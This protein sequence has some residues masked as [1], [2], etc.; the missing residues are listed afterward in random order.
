MHGFFPSER[1]ICA[2]LY[3]TVFLLILA[4]LYYDNR[5]IRDTLDM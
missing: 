3:I 5:D 1:E 2:S 4:A